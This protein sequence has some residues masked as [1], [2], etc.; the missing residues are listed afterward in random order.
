MARAVAIAQARIGGAPA[1]S[2]TAE[3][4]AA[5]TDGHPPALRALATPVAPA[6]IVDRQDV[7]DT[8][9]NPY[10]ALFVGRIALTPAGDRAVVITDHGVAI[11]PVE[12]A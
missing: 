8:V 3:L 7:G 11:L 12:P 5:S 4:R 9:T 10:H 6:G 2:E 1:P